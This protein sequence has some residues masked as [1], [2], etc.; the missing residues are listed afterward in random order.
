MLAVSLR[1]TETTINF[2]C[3]GFQHLR[4]QGMR[5]PIGGSKDVS[6]LTDVT[7]KETALKSRKLTGLPLSLNFGP[8]VDRHACRKPHFRL[9]KTLPRT[10]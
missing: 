8:K 7:W 5:N 1:P 9:Q 3:T 6:T 10:Q 4:T 2:I